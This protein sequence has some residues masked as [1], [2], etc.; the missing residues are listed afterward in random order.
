MKRKPW[1]WAGLAVAG[2]IC[3]AAAIRG[4][5]VNS[6]LQR[7]AENDT[8]LRTVVVDFYLTH[9]RLPEAW[10]AEQLGITAGHWPG[11][12][13]AAP[14]VLRHAVEGDKAVYQVFTEAR[15]TQFGLAWR[16]VVSDASL[17]KRFALRRM[18]CAQDPALL[19]RIGTAEL[20]QAPGKA[21][22]GG[23]VKG[24]VLAAAS[25]A[26]P[27]PAVP[28]ALYEHHFDA[29]RASKIGNCLASWPVQWRLPYFPAMSAGQCDAQAASGPGGIRKTTLQLGHRPNWFVAQGERSGGRMA[30]AAAAAAHFESLLTTQG[31]TRAQT[32]ASERQDSADDAMPPNAVYLRGSGAD[33]LRIS[34]RY[35]LDSTML[36]IE[37]SAPAAVPASNSTASA[38]GTPPAAKPSTAGA[39]APM[40]T[41]GPAMSGAQLPRPAAMASLYESG[42]FAAW[43]A[44][45]GLKLIEERVGGGD[46][47]TVP[48]ADID[49]KSV[50]PPDWQYVQRA[51][52]TGDAEQLYLFSFSRLLHYRVQPAIPRAELLAAY[53]QAL[54]AA[55]WTLGEERAGT[56]MDELKASFKFPDR[57][58]GA[59]IRLHENEVYVNVH[60]RSFVERVYVVGHSMRQRRGYHLTPQLTGSAKAVADTRQQLDLLDYHLRENASGTPASRHNGVLLRPALVQGQENDPAKLAEAKTMAQALAAEFKQRGWAD[61]RIRV[62]DKREMSIIRPDGLFTHGVR[63][64]P[65]NCSTQDSRGAPGEKNCVC[66][67]GSPEVFSATAGVCQ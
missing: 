18:E 55:G 59:A 31:F 40:P 12:T 67:A 45:S 37:G 53:R 58:I 19:A 7:I 6:A 57:S 9:G 60:D 27:A 23:A 56:G 25:P 26:A 50:I 17:E 62:I 5:G 8:R 41:G 1:L 65:Y 22:A 52:G 66:H 13:V 43:F 47:Y 42:H 2:A 4:G 51:R 21:A 3:V 11:M 15:G 24:A 10:D 35:S 29:G 14:G 28:Q 64:S 38:P 33:A 61:E 16:C 36:S 39:A 63:V 46:A 30:S 32:P 54:P 20:A 49:P 44:L 48:L 34:L